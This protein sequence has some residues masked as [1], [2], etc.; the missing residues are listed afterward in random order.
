MPENPRVEC[1]ALEVQ[2]AVVFR[3][4]VQ[5]ASAARDS[6]KLGDHA[7]CVRN[8]MQDVAAYGEI[9]TAIGGAQLE[10]ALVLER[11]PGREPG[12]ARASEIQMMVDDID[13]EHA[14]FWKEFGQPRGAFTGAAAGVE[15]AGLRR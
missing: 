15:Y 13:A 9:E 10:D 4:K 14:G 3:N 7:V 11:Q 2:H 5:V 8:G 12:V 6:R 1:A